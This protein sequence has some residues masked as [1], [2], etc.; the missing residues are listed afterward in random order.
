MVKQ[1]KLLMGQ[2]ISDDKFMS[3]RVVCIAG[4]EGLL[5]S[6]ELNKALLDC[7][8]HYAK[9]TDIRLDPN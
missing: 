5:G 9:L 8:R 6:L 1:I 2:F 7:S 3:M 4:D